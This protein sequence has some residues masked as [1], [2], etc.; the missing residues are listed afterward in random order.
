M[1]CSTTKAVEWDAAWSKN[2]DP[3]GRAALGVHDAAYE[4]TPGEAP[5]AIHPVTDN[6]LR[7]A[8]GESLVKPVA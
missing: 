2:L 8:I 7:P 6:S 5:A 3:S 4:D 1:A